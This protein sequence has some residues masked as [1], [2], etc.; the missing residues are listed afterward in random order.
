MFAALLAVTGCSIDVIDG[1]ALDNG[2]EAV[3]GDAG[4]LVADVGRGGTGQG[5]DEPLG[6]VPGDVCREAAGWCDAVEV[7]TD[8]CECPDDAVMPQGSMP[9][10]TYDLIAEVCAGATCDGTHVNCPIYCD[11]VAPN[12]CIDGWHCVEPYCLPDD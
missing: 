5:G 6:C 10:A 2:H 1:T 8:A 12:G 9:D 3:G 11:A 4:G 7:W